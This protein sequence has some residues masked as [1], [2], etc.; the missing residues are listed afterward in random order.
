MQCAVHSQPTLVS[1]LQQDE[2]QEQTFSDPKDIQGAYDSR[3]AY[4]PT[5]V[6]YETIG[7]HPPLSAS[8]YGRGSGPGAPGHSAGVGLGLHIEHEEMNG[9]PGGRQPHHNVPQQ[10]YPPQQQYQ[11][12]VHRSVSVNGNAH[13]QYHDRE[14]DRR[15]D[16]RIRDRERERVRD[17]DDEMRDVRALVRLSPFSP[18][19]ACPY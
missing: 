12:Q 18:S 15:E 10:Q 1:I 8:N 13:A 6:P 17:R 11:P 2:Q 5:H 4:Y 19:S 3:N 7:Y 16:V 9:A 14:Y